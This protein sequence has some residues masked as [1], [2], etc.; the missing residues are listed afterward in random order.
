MIPVALG[1]SNRLAVDFALVGLAKPVLVGI[2]V[3]A[4][5]YCAYLCVRCSDGPFKGSWLP[6]LSQR[7]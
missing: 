3:A 5:A 1:S 4:G 2:G 7:P 6:W